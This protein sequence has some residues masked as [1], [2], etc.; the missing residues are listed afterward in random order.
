[1]EKNWRFHNFDLPRLKHLSPG[2]FWW[3]LTHTD[4]TEFYTSFCNLNIRGLGKKSWNV[5]FCLCFIFEVF[6]FKQN[7]ST[8]FHV[9]L[10]NSTYRILSWSQFNCGHSLNWAHFWETSLLVIIL[11]AN[12]NYIFNHLSNVLFLK[13]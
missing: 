13:K 2:Q 7:C 9:T 5:L 11:G 12:F 6:Q 8:F 3:T 10:L 1:M 4:I